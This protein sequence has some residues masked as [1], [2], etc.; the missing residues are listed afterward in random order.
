MQNKTRWKGTNPMSQ[1]LSFV[2]MVRRCA[3][4]HGYAKIM[5]FFITSMDSCHFCQRDQN[6]A[7]KVNPKSGWHLFIAIFCLV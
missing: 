2:L 7:S 6:M 1:L 4:E 5:E 3:P